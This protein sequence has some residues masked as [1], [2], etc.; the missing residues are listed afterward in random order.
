MEVYSFFSVMQ[1]AHSHTAPLGLFQEG[2]GLGESTVYSIIIWICY[3]FY[4]LHFTW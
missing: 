3:I 2:G 1:K 4:I